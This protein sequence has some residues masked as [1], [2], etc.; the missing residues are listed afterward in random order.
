MSHQWKV[1]KMK[2]GLLLVL[3]LLFVATIAA[4][5]DFSPIVMTI[6]GQDQILYSFDGSNLDIPVT[7]TGTPAAIWLVINTK[8]K[9]CKVAHTRNGYIGWHFVNKI[10][11]KIFI[12]DRYYR[13]PGA[14][15]SP[16]MVKTRPALH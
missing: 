2:K 12:S 1:N 9:A 5:V 10:D 7:L 8:D 6:T 11:T 13:T 4:A 14:Q 3:A 15:Q 16:G